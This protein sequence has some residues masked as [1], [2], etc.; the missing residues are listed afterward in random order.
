MK[1]NDEAYARGLALLDR[2]H[3]GRI[4][5]EVFKAREAEAA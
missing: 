1:K 2:L 3:G 5:D 4:A